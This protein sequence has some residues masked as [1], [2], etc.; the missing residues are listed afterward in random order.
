MTNNKASKPKETNK[1][2]SKEPKPTMGTTAKQPNPQPHPANDNDDDHHQGRHHVKSPAYFL[3]ATTSLDTMPHA[4]GVISNMSDYAKLSERFGQEFS[5]A[6]ST[7]T[8]LQVTR[9]ERFCHQVG[10]AP[11]LMVR[12]LE[13]LFTKHKIPMGLM[14]KLFGLSDFDVVEFIIDDSNSMH[15]SY[16]S[17]HD[18][19]KNG[20][21]QQQQQQTNTRWTQ[22]QARLKELLELVAFVPLSRIQVSFLDRPTEL[23]WTR[24]DVDGHNH[25]QPHLFLKDAYADIDACFALGPTDTPTQWEH[26]HDSMIAGR[27]KEKVACFFL[28][29]GLPNA[30]HLAHHETFQALL[31]RPNPAANPVTFLSCTD[32]QAHRDWMKQ[33]ASIVPYCTEWDDYAASKDEVMSAQGR[34]LPYTKGFHLICELVSAMYPDDLGMIKNSVPLTKA[35]LD[36]LLGIRLNET[37]YRYYFDEFCQAQQ[38]DT[39][40]N[41]GNDNNPK[42][43]VKRNFSWDVDEFLRIPLAKASSQVAEY[44]KLLKQEATQF[45]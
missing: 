17:P 19:D 37:T 38:Q 11:D 8:A 34:A 32:D 42:D 14:N 21:Q 22:A 5:L 7:K 45:G 41:N 30:R 15:C 3:G 29:D 28:T 4:L 20:Q 31:Q 26:L 18:A 10:F 44:N 13:E 2:T 33:A 12:Q 1:Q 9:D 27:H 36:T 16:V 25:K 24:Q 39:N 6:E 35:T 43:K 23:I 40:N